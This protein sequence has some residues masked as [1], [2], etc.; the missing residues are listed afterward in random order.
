MHYAVEIL[1]NEENENIIHR[2]SCLIIS[3]KIY[4]IGEFA[5]Y[6]LAL[7]RAK[8]LGFVNLNGC[9]WCCY[10]HL[11]PSAETAESSAT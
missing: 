2:T 6:D 4:P 1:E 10:W 7:S 3:G 9:Y 5:T 8:Q 11:T